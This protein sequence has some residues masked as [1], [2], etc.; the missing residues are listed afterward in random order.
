MD[1]PILLSLDPSSTC[2][3][4]AVFDWRAMRLIEAGR[5]RP[6]QSKSSEARIDQMLNDLDV[7]FA[8]C[9]PSVVV[10]EVPTGRQYSR[11]GRQSSLA[12]W[13]FAAGAV[14]ASVRGWAKVSDCT[15]CQVSNVEWT[16]GRSKESRIR[17]A[18]MYGEYD[19]A[20]DGGGDAADA[21]CLAEWWNRRN[22]SIQVQAISQ[23]A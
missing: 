9:K 11:K 19:S 7:L 3:G 15:I 12:V 4:Y 1:A 23:N 17:R 10:I 2:T 6:I 18:S 14:W 13:G 20:K 8:E 16:R 21:I 5:L 22:A